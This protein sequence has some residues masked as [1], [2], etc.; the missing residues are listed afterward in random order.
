MVPVQLER[1]PNADSLSL[2]KVFHYSV[3]VRTVDWIDRKIGAYICPDSVVPDTPEYAFLNGHRRIKVRKLRGIISMGLLMPAP[4]GAVIGQDVAERM[5]VLHYEPPDTTTGGENVPPPPG[6]HPNYD[7]DTMYRYAHLFKEGEPVIVTE[8]IHGA[9]GRWAWIDGQM[10]CGSRNLWK[11]ED[12]KSVWWRALRRNVE[13]QDF[14]RE[15]P[16]ITVYGEVYGWVQ[17]LRYG[18]KPGEVDIAVFDLLDGQEWIAGAQARLIGEELPWVPLI[19][20]GP[21]IREEIFKMADGPSFIPNVEH[22]REGVVVKPLNE[23]TD[24]EIG[25]LQLKIVSSEYLAGTK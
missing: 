16:G 14:C 7:V 13:V 1:H 6:Y 24:P 21:F 9:N 20:Y 22:E 8:K 25:R 12:D 2:V 15:H 17:S 19:Y 18:R 23:R 11:K 5:G 3:I 10:Y 4:D